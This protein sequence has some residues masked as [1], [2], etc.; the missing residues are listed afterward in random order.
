VH[1]GGRRLVAVAIFVAAAACSSSSSTS[2]NGSSAATVTCA[3]SADGCRCASSSFTLASGETA[4]SSCDIASGEV[5]CC[6]DSDSSGEAT[7]CSCRTYRCFDLENGGCTCDYFGDEHPPPA[8]GTPAASCKSTRAHDSCCAGDGYSCDCQP[9]PGGTKFAC[10][11]GTGVVDECKPT[12]TTGCSLTTCKDV[13][14]KAPATGGGGGS[15]SSGSSSGCTYDSQCH[16]CSECNA[17]RG[18]SCT[19]GHK[20]SS[21]SCIY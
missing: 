21:G 14:Y 5:S 15:S 12:P 6:A 13:K 10:A 1:E 9:S 2:A 11:T 7:T 19:C 3:T 4:S 18:G 16:A 8:G 17:C 20:G